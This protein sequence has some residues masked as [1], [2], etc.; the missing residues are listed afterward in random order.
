MDELKGIAAFGWRV[1]A[2]AFEYLAPPLRATSF[3]SRAETERVLAAGPLALRAEADRV[4]AARLSS[5]Q[6]P[7]RQ[8]LDF[9]VP[10]LQDH[11]RKAPPLRRIA[12]N[13]CCRERKLS[14]V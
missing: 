6:L 1:V 12:R 8:P 10:V 2:P 3:P 7:L 5:W 14:K 11:F 9:F 13:Q 4:Q